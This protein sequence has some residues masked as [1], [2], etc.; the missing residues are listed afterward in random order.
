M[1]DNMCP[2]I[3]DSSIY[4]RWNL[5]PFLSGITAT[6]APFCDTYRDPFKKHFI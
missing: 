2:C 5:L 6:T 3:N 4:L 1:N